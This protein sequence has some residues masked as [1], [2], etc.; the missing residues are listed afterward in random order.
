VAGVQPRLLRGRD[1]YERRTE[2][3][4]D[5]LDADAPTHTVRLGDDD[6]AVEVVMLALPSPSYEIREASCRALA[7]DLPGT[8]CMA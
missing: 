3:W 8:S 6:T 5:N 7:G 1:R 4:T 2:A